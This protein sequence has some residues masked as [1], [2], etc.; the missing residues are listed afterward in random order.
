MEDDLMRLFGTERLL[1]V[2]DAMKMPEDMPIDAK[3]LSDAIERAQKRIE[4]ANFK[5]RKYVLSYDDVMNQQRSLIYKQRQDVLDGEDISDTVRK[6]ITATVDEYVRFFTAED[7][8]ADWTLDALRAHFMGY[9]TTEEDFRYSEEELSGLTRDGLIESLTDRAMSRYEEKE[10][11]FGSEV[12]REVERAVLLKSVDSSW[13]EHIDVMDDLKDTVRLQAYAQRDP[14]TEYRIQG[15]DL[16]DTMVNDIR[17]NTVRTILSVVSR[18][19]PIRSVQ[20]ANPIMAGF[21]GGEPK[22]VVVKKQ[23][24]AASAKSAGRN[25]PCP[26]GSGKKYKNCCMRSSGEE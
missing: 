25:D 19:Q 21:S 16:F 15:A 14:V 10:Q 18:Q 8:A 23:V 7:D 24:P 12:F 3:L 5:R 6:M 26:C 11:L 9:L 20:V 2:V 1:A 4:D 17:Q 13:M 22:K